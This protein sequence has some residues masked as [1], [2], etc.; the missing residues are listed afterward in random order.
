MF[1]IFVA[2]SSV[3]VGVADLSE[4]AGVV[5]K[6]VAQIDRLEADLADVVAVQ[7]GIIEYEE[8]LSKLQDLSE[9]TLK[10]LPRVRSMDDF[11]SELLA[12]FMSLAKLNQGTS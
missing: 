10:D 12:E 7:R 2:G 9:R 6:L 11:C 1:F 3:V 5:A 8:T 4:L